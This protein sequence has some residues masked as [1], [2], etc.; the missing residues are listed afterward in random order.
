MKTEETFG[1]EMHNTCAH[2]IKND[3][4]VIA[5]FTEN[6]KYVGKPVYNAQLFE[7]CQKQNCNE[8]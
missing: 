5:L 1:K 2:Q 8:S 4:N 7:S 6:R 3:R